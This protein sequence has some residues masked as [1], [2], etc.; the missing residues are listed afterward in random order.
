MGSEIGFADVVNGC[1][2]IDDQIRPVLYQQRNRIDW[3]NAFLKNILVIPG[4]FADG[5]PDLSAFVGKNPALFAGFK[6]PPFIKHVVCRQQPF[7]GLVQDMPVFKQ[8]RGIEKR[9]P[10]ICGIFFHKP[11]D[12]SD[13]LNPLHDVFHGFLVR[14]NKFG[15]LQQITGRVAGNRQFGKNNQIAI[16][17]FGFFRVADQAIA[18]VNKIADNRID[19]SDADFHEQPQ[20]PFQ[21]GDMVLSRSMMG[22]SFSTIRS[23]SDSVL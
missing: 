14:L 6:I 20:P 21:N 19:L 5:Q 1:R 10:L 2:K 7:A 13:P 4:I 18:V 22:G 23:T 15:L 8:K 11:A 16:T 3:V 9:I 17:R 12:D